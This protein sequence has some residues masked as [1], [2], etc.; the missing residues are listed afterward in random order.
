[1]YVFH[2]VKTELRIFEKDCV[3]ANILKLFLTV[4]WLSRH[5]RER[6]LQTKGDSGTPNVA[7][8]TLKYI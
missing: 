5:D 8:L 3:A 4:F 2:F 6:R 1:M 7:N